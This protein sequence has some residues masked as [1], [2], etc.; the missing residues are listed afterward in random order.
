MV[1]C[2]IEDVKTISLTQFSDERGHLGIVESLQD[3]PFSLKRLFYVH[4]VPSG[5]VRGHHAHRLCEQALVCLAGA[6]QVTCDDGTKKREFMLNDPAQ[7]LYVPPSIWAEE[8][9]IEQGSIL[10]V[11][12]DRT[13]EPIDYLRDYDDFLR[14]RGLA[15]S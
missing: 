1:F 10:L 14:F 13:Y 5:Q 11:L 7:A 6:I 2:N 15:V 8:K 9:Y 12:T 4:G 3:V